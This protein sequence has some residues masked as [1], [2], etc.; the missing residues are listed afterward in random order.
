MNRKLKVLQFPI[1]NAKGGIT[2]YA[3]QNWKLIDKNRF[4]FDFATRSPKLDFEDELIREGCKIHYLSCSSEENEKQFIKEVHQIL[5]DGYDV[6]HLHTSYWKG[7]LVEELA[8]ERNVPIIIIHSHSTNV[9]IFNDQKR[10]ESLEIHEYYKNTLPLEYGTNFLACSKDAADWLFGEQIPREKI[11]IVNN[12]I[13]VSSY[14]FSSQPRNE[15]RK[16]LGIEDCFVLGHIGRFVYQKNHEFLIEIFKAVYDKLPHARLVLVGGGELESDIKEKVEEYGLTHA[17][18]FLGKRNDVP[19]LLQAMDV[20]L[21]PSRFEGLGLVLVEAQASGLKCIA[22]HGVPREAKVTPDLQ[23]LDFSV[24]EWV[25]NIL[26]L[27]N[28]YRREINDD[29]IKEAGYDLIDQIKVIE[30]LYEGE[31]ISNDCPSAAQKYK[32]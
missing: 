32:G 25:N 11:F 20:F 27:A 2:Q 24:D 12:A 7:Y 3:L 14:S 31:D 30:K 17:V 23:F 16:L 1:A 4:Q 26:Q 9:D 6:V 8:L 19:Q 10:K 22:S 21:L 28:G 15:Y 29:L 18:L 13:D 5:D